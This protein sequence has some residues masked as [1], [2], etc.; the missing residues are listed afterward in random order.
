MMGGDSGGFRRP[1]PYVIHPTAGPAMIH[2][3][4]VGPSL[5]ILGGRAV[6]ANRLLE[7]RTI[8][9]YRDMVAERLPGS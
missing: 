8:D 1:S 4:L 5:D 9:R 7:R 3:T 6:H 2:V